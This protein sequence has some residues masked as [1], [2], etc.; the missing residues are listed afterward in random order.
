MVN[1]YT[2]LSSDAVRGL[3]PHTGA[4]ALFQ[5]IYIAPVATGTF[6]SVDPH[7]LEI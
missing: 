4:G 5:T 1:I 2:A 7:H 3:T 6:I